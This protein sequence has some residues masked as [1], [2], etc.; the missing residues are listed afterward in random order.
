MKKIDIFLISW[1]FHSG[2]VLKHKW[3][4]YT[5]TPP[6]GFDVHST[7]VK[8]R[9][10]SSLLFATLLCVCVC[11][12]VAPPSVKQTHR[13]VFYKR[14]RAEERDKDTSLTWS[15]CFPTSHC[16]LWLAGSTHQCPKADNTFKCP[17]HSKIWRNR[18][19][20]QTEVRVTADTK[21]HHI[22]LVGQR[23]WRGISLCVSLY[24]SLAI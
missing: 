23:W 1:L 2:Y 16:M 6:W 24:W 18:N 12:C 13:A 19:N 3:S 4:A 9:F 22:A 11:M 15:L 21:K 10:S 20:I 17:A 8:C 5:S 7:K 14:Q